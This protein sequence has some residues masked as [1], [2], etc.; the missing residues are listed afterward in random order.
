M[1]KTTADLR[2]YYE[3]EARRRLREKLGRRRVS[4]RNEYIS[5]LQAESRPSVIDFGA[6]PGL[7]IDGFVAAGLHA[8][9]LDLAHGNGVLASERGVTVVQASIDAPPIRSGSFQAGW[10]MS[11]LMHIPDERMP[12]TLASMA[13][14]LAP[15]AP[16]FVGQWGGHGDEI[17]NHRI[18]GEQ[19]LFSLRSFARNRELLAA[20][21]ELQRAEILPVGDDGWE[22]HVMMVRTMS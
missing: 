8:V 13:V 7:D 1:D 15:G 10:S 22:Y 16:L 3:E 4:E 6:G 20:V 19:R 5:L 11:T 9:G 21:G 2:S 18:E 12:D 17:D 14:V